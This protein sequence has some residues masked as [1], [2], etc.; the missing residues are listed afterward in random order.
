MLQKSDKKF[1]TRILIFIVLGII[2][3]LKIDSI[4]KFVSNFLSLLAPLFVAI[5]IALVL[6]RPNEFFK[7]QF[8]KIPYFNNQKAKIPSIIICYILFLGVIVG[9]FLIMIPQ[10]MDSF[11]EFVAQFDNYKSSFNS[12]INAVS[13]WVKQFNVDPEIVSNLGDKGLEIIGKAINSLPNILSSFLSKTVSIFS[14]FFLG[15]IISIYILSDKKRLKRQ[16]MSVISAITPEKI[17]A[18]L[19]HI[20]NV[21]QITFANYLYIQLTEGLILGFLYFI[22]MSIFG[23]PYALIISV[24]NGLSVLIPIVGAWLGAIGGGVIVLFTKPQSL[25]IYLVLVVVVQVLE[26]NLIY[27]HRVKDA[28][29]LPAMWVLVSVAMGGGLFGILGALLAVPTGSIIY[30]LIS[31]GVDRKTYKKRLLDNEKLQ[32]GHFDNLKNDVENSQSNSS[33]KDEK[34]INSTKSDSK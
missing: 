19:N 5:A 33:I 22:T 30:Q 10:V 16:F 15:L 7:R 27:P 21:I 11:T 28:V 12:T 13:D 24:F 4:A 31:E 25:I 6:N 1:I 26:N 3:A 8:R 20:L 29:G 18:K 9:L 32:E 17:Y 34:L 14:S 23:F 2:I